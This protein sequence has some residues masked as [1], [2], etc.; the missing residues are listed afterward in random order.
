MG[1]IAT[2]VDDGEDLAAASFCSFVVSLIRQ[3]SVRCRDDMQDIDF[4]NRTQVSGC[5]ASFLWLVSRQLPDS[6]F[7][8]TLTR[9]FVA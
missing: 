8:L 7:I 9:P 2:Q 6:H 4:L 5:L 3:L 1:E